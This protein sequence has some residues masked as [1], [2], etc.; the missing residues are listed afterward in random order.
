V[1]PEQFYVSVAIGPA[2]TLIVVLVGV[3]LNNSRINQFENSLN[4]RIDD[5]D[6]H[7]NQRID[8]LRDVLRAEMARDHS[9]MLMKFAD[10]D[11]RINGLD[12]RLTRIENS[13]GLNRP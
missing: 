1:S 4:K 8:D 9:E 6:R 12:E 7:L 10:L 5:L 2:V 3:F 11:H 13:L